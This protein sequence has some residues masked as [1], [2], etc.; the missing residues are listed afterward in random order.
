MAV[1]TKKVNNR[2]KLRFESYDDLIADATSLASNGYQ[3][4]GNWELAQMLDHLTKLHIGSLEG[5]VPD[6]PL[7]FRIL[8]QWLFK[9]TFLNKGLPA[10]AS[11][12]DAL[13]AIV[14]P[15]DDVE[16]EEALQRFIESCERLK[17]NPHREKHPFLG[18]LSREDWDKFHFRHAELHLSFLLPE[19]AAL[20]A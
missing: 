6:G 3:K 18:N 11:P 5:G 2:R 15:S 19:A 10:G 20:S 16:T 17:S 4:L 14:G 8:A 9:S 1:E 13:V 7:P 12:P